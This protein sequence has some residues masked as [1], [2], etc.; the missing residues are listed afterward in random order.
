MSDF[1]NMRAIAGGRPINIFGLLRCA[2][3]P[4]AIASRQ[5]VSRWYDEKTP[6]QPDEN[7][8]GIVKHVI[9]QPVSPIYLIRCRLCNRGDVATAVLAAV[10]GLALLQPN[11]GLA[12]RLGLAAARAGR[13]DLLVVKQPTNLGDS[14]IAQKRLEPDDSRQRHS[15]E[16]F[17]IETYREAN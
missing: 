12:K 15:R 9:A 6:A 3:L 14:R 17:F 1:F 4:V 10:A 16:S 8:L 11:G 7:V 13:A 5:F 2:R